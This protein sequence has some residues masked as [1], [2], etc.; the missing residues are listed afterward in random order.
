M[1]L[2]TIVT[3]YT[4]DIDSFFLSLVVNGKVLKNCMIDSGASNTVMPFKIMEVFGLKVD[5]KQGSCCALDFRE[6]PV[7]G[8]ISAM[9]YKLVS[10]PDHELTMSVLVVDIPP[11]YG[12]LLSRKWSATM[13]GNLQCD[14]SFATFHVDNKVVKIKRESR[15]TYMIEDTRDET[16]TC[17][18]DTDI[19]T[20][21]AE[22]VILEKEKIPALISQEAIKCSEFTEVW[23][24]Y[25]DGA[26][27]KEG[28]GAGAR[29][30][31]ISP[32]KN[33][34]RYSFTLNFTCT[35]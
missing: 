10:Y 25:F 11:R 3:P 20:F 15:V 2:D 28:A 22:L 26:S 17:F 29:V 27:S 9:P 16:T 1:Y 23:T 8:T 12:M 18:L 34:F 32:T 24:M 13:G 14:L 7:I 21:R 19:N 5:T 35:K 33:T 4:E 30:V 31:F 6:V